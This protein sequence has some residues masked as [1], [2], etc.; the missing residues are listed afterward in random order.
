YTGNATGAPWGAYN[1]TDDVYLDEDFIYDD[2][3]KTHLVGCCSCPEGNLT[4]PSIVVSIGNYAF[5]GCTGLTTVTIPNTV[6]SIGDYAFRDCTGL[7][8]VTIPN[9]VTS[10]GGGA[11]SLCTGLTSFSIPNSVTTID[12]S[13][14]HSCT[15]LTSVTIPN[16]VT[17][18]GGGAFHNC[19]G[20]SSVTIPNSVTSI[21]NFAFSG[22]S[23]LTSVTIPNSITDISNYAFRDCRGLT[24]LTIPNSV[25]SIGEYAFW[26]CSGL[27]SVTI[28]NSV[29]FIGK[30]AFRTCS[31][32]T[33]LTI[34]NSVSSIGNS[35][36]EDC[37]ELREIYSL[38]ATPPSISNNSFYR[39]PS[40]IPVHVPCGRI[41]AYQSV[42][43]CF[44]NFIDVFSVEVFSAEPQ[45]GSAEVTVPYS[46]DTPHVIVTANAHDGYLFDYWSDGSTDNPYQLT[47]TCDTSLIAYFVEGRTITVL[48]ENEDKGFVLGSGVYLEG[49]TTEI[50]ALAN[51]GYHFDH[52]NDGNTDNPR[53][54]TVAGNATYTAYFALNQYTLSIISNNDSQGNVYGG[55]SYDYLSELT[56]SA[57]ANY[58]YHF[59]NWNDGNT[60]N[61]R[62]VTVT[63]DTTYTAYFVPNQYTIT[64]N[65]D[66]SSHGIVYGEGSFD[67]LSECTLFAVANDGYHF[68]HWNDGNTYNPRAITITQDMT[69]IA[70]FEANQYTLTLR[71][72]DGSQGSVSG[73]GTFNYL[74]TVTIS[75]TAAAH[76]HFIKWSDNNRENPRRYVITGDKTLTATFAIDVHT[77]SVAVDDI[78]HGSVQ[79][80][81]TTFNY[82]SPC[83]VTATAYSGYTFSGWSNGMTDNPYTFAVLNDVDL[84]AY[85]VPTGSQPTTYY[86]VTAVSADPSMGSVV[87]GGSYASGTTAT[88]TA[89]ANSG[90]HFT[91]WQDN[92]TSN[93]RTVTVTGNATYTAYFESDG[94]GEQP[95]DNAPSISCVGVDM[96][97]HNV[98]RWEPRQGV[99]VVR[100]NIYRE[101]LGGYSIVG[102]VNA[103]NATEYSWVDDNSNTATQ[104][105]GYKLS[106]VAANGTESDLS[107][108]HTT[109]HLQISQGQGTTWNLSWTPYVGFNYSGY[110]IYR[111]N[112]SAS[113]SLLTELSSSATTYSDNAPNG[114]VYYQIEV[115]ASS[116][117]SITAS[118]RSNIATSV[119]N[120]QFTIT[121]LS[122]NTSMGTVTGG[123]TF[124]EGTTATISAN[125]LSG[126]TFT[127]WSDGS[128]QAQR[129]ITVT[130][131]ATYTAY[132][133]AS[134][135]EPQQYLITVVSNNPERGTVTGGGLFDA[136]TV[137][138]ITA[139]SFAGYQFVQWQDGNAEDFR[140][141]TVTAD[142]TY[143]AYFRTATEGIDDV[144]TAE[145]IKVYTRGNSIV[146][147]TETE[148]IK[149][150]GNQA[151]VVYDVMGRVIRTEAIKHSDNQIVI[152]VT[153]AGVYMVKIG[154]GK[155][156]KVLV[157]P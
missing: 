128:T 39:V 98:V 157:R 122:D 42:W 30:S 76:H 145:N 95:S 13:T 110:R 114:D 40:E 130:G 38:N 26:G 115:V 123:G 19:T 135:S 32:L 107:T 146:I 116:A 51:Y 70:F 131:N 18:I 1:V 7:S 139:E 101:G 81:G 147:E 72:N 104:S 60:E 89:S 141:I 65:C 4:I 56:I 62:T 148:T 46:C 102:Y 6:T 124:A 68:S 59:E 150:S 10:I 8:S 33:S 78:S 118:S 93:P 36:F 91:H 31:G 94:G 77:V 126:Y 41:N 153:S 44:S 96:N 121:V 79:A 53:I 149:H 61:P 137:I 142:A 69:Y 45:M 23:G 111:G 58:G 113:M 24:S 152:P 119:Q 112:S 127:Q 129:T 21:G 5:H 34:G 75:A 67:Y 16:T 120:Q 17:S 151:I 155:P 73:G 22:C 2:A 140:T 54:V 85:F 144:D 133:T 106:E 138:T 103:T 12:N 71:S 90:Y 47:L 134:G 25:A 66:N 14:F 156:H 132:F 74:D 82:G 9:S 97:G 88:L 83:T 43:S 154:D 63:G 20:L 29:T 35:A 11:F 80:S 49:G 87:G 99:S 52:W 136:G 57:T 143:T 3:S 86:T 64:V 37:T 84:I 27:T 92:A 48:S 50:S 105:Y 109:M 55:G 15:G 100:Y 108:P 117:K 125:P 28:P